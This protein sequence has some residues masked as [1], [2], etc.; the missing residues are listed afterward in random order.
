MKNAFRSAVI[1]TLFTFSGQIVLFI[2]QM[3]TAAIFGANTEM[4]AFL[5]ANTLPQYIIS[6]LLGSLGFVFIPFFID[7]KAKGSEEKA[8]QLAISLF[9]NCILFLLVI[10]I[11]GI[12]FAKPLLQLTAPGLSPHALEVGV[13]IAIITWPTIIATGALSLLSSIYQAEKRFNWQAAVPFIGAIVNLV[14]LLF[15]ARTFGVIGLAIASTCGVVVQVFMLLRIIANRGKYKFALNWQDTGV[16]QIFKLVAPLIFV[17]IVTKFTP[18]IDRYLASGLQEGSISHLNYA[19]K[20]TAIISV[21]ISTGGATVIF[22][23]MALDASNSDLSAL[24]STM[25]FGLRIMWLI[26]APVITIG[27]SLSLPVVIILFNRGEFTDADSVAVATLF[28]IY[29][30]ALIAMGLGNV[31]GKGF[32]V[33]KD[34]KTL[35]IFGV[36]ETI[37]YAIY[38]IFLTKWLGVIGI[39]I[40]YVIYFNISLIWQLLILKYKTGGKGVGAIARS[41]IKTFFAALSGGILAYFVTLCIHNVLLQFVI[42]GAAGFLSYIS[43]LY[44]LGSQEIEII[45]NIIRF[46]SPASTNI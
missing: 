35:A 4:D 16:H 28:K 27:I 18:V 40:G 21:L 38:T 26:I 46:K 8:Y 1:I 37:A 34:T 25:S 2:A 20:I 22:P 36:I 24:R 43:I 10:T 29:L 5:A 14:L 45:K 44:L 12:I 19:F 33:L 32:Y 3:V 11:L 41:F 9:N 15:L 13:R 23:K 6:V 31:T 7:Y 39:A 42:G 17:A 30:I